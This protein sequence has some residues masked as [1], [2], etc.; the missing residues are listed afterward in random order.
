METILTSADGDVVLRRQVVEGVRTI[1]IPRDHLLESSLIVEIMSIALLHTED[2]RHRLFPRRHDRI[3]RRISTWNP[4][5]R[6]RLPRHDMSRAGGI[7]LMPGIMMIIVVRTILEVLLH[8]LHI[9]HRH[10]WIRGGLTMPM[11]GDLNTNELFIPVQ[12]ILEMIFLRL[13]PI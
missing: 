9:L 12:G 7:P 4:G 8:H 13:L 2:P 11:I 1:E 10:T 3:P 5:A 6:I